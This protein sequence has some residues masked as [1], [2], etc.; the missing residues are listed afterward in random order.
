MKEFAVGADWISRSSIVSRPGDDTPSN[1]PSLKQET[2]LENY[3]R[4]FQTT[5]FEGAVR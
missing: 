4:R 3:S 1:A 2:M 5:L